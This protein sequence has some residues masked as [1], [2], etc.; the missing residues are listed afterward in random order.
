MATLRPALAVEGPDLLVARLSLRRALGGL[1][2][3]KRGRGWGW[4]RHGDC[5]IGERDRLLAHRLI[6]RMKGVVMCSEDLVERF[7][8]ILQHMKAISNLGR[9][10]RALT[11][12]LG[13]RTRPIPRNHLHPGVLPEPLRH[14]LGGA[15]REQG[16]RLA[17]FQVDQDRAI[18]VPFAQ[19]EIVHPQHPGRGQD[20]QR[21]PAQPAQQ[22]V[23]AH[24][25]SPRVA[26]T[27][28]GRAP[29]GHPEGHEALG[30]PP[31]APRPRGSDGG[32]P[33][34]EETPHAVGVV[35]KP[36]AHAQL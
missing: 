9:L 14:R 12:A 22:G 35:T 5:P 26:Q 17:A 7:P 6:D 16:H 29:Q 21:Q 19:G 15:F 23:P 8:K 30:Q 34:G 3:D 25:Q 1:L 31:G 11:R 13:I 36:L 24:G 4:Y 10:G 27:Y 32:Q 2:L 18:G 33:F 20:G 28:P